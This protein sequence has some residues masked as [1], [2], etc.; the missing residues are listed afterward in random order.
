M[1]LEILSYIANIENLGNILNEISV[2]VYDVNNILARKSIET[3]G[4]IA[5]RLEETV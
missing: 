4:K 5:C 2:Y 1:K 3:L